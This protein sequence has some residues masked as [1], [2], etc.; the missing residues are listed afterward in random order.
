MDWAKTIPITEPL[1]LTSGPP[2]LP[3]IT[4]VSY[5]HLDVYKRQAMGLAME[6][7]MPLIIFDAMQPDSILEV[8][9]GKPA[10]TKISEA[11]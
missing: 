8:V 4:S 11:N 6:H 1:V 9:K 10:G 7:A 3:G 5:T 2:E